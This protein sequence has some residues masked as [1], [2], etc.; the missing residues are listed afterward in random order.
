MAQQHKQHW[1]KSV[2]TTLTALLGL[3]RQ[4]PA[5]PSVRSE[6]EGAAVPL[7][8]AGRVPV[9]F[10]LDNGPVAVGDKLTFI[11]ASGEAVKAGPHDITIEPPRVL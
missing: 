3:Y 10:R 5:S 4:H 6:T 1:L 11:E 9:K 8:L 7:A 2:L